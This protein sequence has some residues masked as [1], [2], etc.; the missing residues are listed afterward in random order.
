M[1]EAQARE[2]VEARFAA[3]WPTASGSVPFNLDNEGGASGDRFADCSIRFTTGDGQLT[4]G[5][6]A[7]RL[8]GRRGVI[9]VR[10]WT[11][12]N[13][14]AA[15]GSALCDA[16]RA[17]LEGESLFVTGEGNPLTIE[18]GETQSPIQDG[19]WWMNT[20]LFRFGFYAV[21]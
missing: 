12:A 20:V 9:Y 2:L 1:T 15:A 17:V 21:H 4:A 11:P 6:D 8:W 14:G 10:I 7:G 18:A 16:A 5:P 13:E 19:R 3:S